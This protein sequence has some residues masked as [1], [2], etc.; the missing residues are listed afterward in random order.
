MREHTSYVYTV[1]LALMVAL[2]WGLLFYP[3]LGGLRQNASQTKFHCAARLPP[4]STGVIMTAGEV[5]P[6]CLHL[7]NVCVDQQVFVMMDPRYN[8]V[9]VD[10]LPLPQYKSKFKYI[11]PV[12]SSSQDVFVSDHTV[13]GPA[14]GSGVSTRA[15]STVHH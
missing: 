5:P 7:E 4:P 9:A 10:H 1:S 14:W 2:P 6:G 15:T 12:T 8:V 3:S 11:P 13:G